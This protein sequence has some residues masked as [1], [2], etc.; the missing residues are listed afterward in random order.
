MQ[1]QTKRLTI[2]K[3]TNGDAP[4]I[5]ALLNTPNWIR[6]IG[7]R[8]IRNKKDAENYIQA[9]ALD[10][11]KKHGYGPYLIS[12]TE[13]NVPIGICGLFKRDNLLHPD[14]GFAFMPEHG[15]KGYA[16]EASEAVINYA[17]EVIKSK[18]LYAV[19]N[20]NNEKSI[21]L[22]LKLGFTPVSIHFNSNSKVFEL[23]AV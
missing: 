1:L 2:R 11:Y 13:T 4:F 16:K 9:W 22:I 23:T 20:S 8:N 7:E 21:S 15:G 10:S 5:K 12:I 17:F 6:F 18:I 19:T 3:L 14:L